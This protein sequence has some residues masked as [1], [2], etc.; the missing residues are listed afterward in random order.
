MAA[1][2]AGGQAGDYGAVA[3]P[4][5]EGPPPARKPRYDFYYLKNRS[6]VLDLTIL[7]RTIP[8]VLWG[9]GAY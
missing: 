3:D 8:S 5:E 4:G 6:L 1:E 9:K 2:E 7:L